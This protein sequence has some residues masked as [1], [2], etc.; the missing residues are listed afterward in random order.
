M[1][2]YFIKNVSKATDKNTNFKDVTIESIH[3]RN[4][5]S[6][7]N[8]QFNIYKVYYAKNYGYTTKAGANSALRSIKKFNEWE[9][10]AGFWKHETPVIITIEA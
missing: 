8:N 6:M 1:E 2:Y 9:N 7:N 5:F 10:A 4:N 3:G